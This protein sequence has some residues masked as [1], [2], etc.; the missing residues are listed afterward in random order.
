MYFIAFYNTIALKNCTSEVNF[1]LPKDS[2]T[3][4]IYNDIFNKEQ[5]LSAV[6]NEYLCFV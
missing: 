6:H 3:T 5:L 1:I 4:D 2:L